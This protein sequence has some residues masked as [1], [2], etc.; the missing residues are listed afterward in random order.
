MKTTC[1]LLLNNHRHR[2]GL[3]EPLEARIAPAGAGGFDLTFGGGDGIA[4]VDHF[5]KQLIESGEAMTVQ[6]D[7][8]IL[9]AG[10]ATDGFGRFFPDLMLVR[11]NAN[12][13][14]DL[15][16]GT[17]G[18][19]TLDFGGSYYS[20]EEAFAI[21]VQ[22][23]GKIIV[24]GR[25]A[26]TNSE[27]APIDFDF[28]MARF[29]A[30]GSLDTG[31]GNGGFV[32]TSMGSQSDAVRGLTVGAGGLIYAVGDSGGDA[33]VARYTSAGAL[34][35]AFDTD[36]KVVR[37]LG[38]A[39]SLRG[40]VVQ[41][42]GKLVAAGTTALDFAAVRFTTSGALDAAFGTAGVALVDFGD[43]GEE[44]RALALD[45]SGKIVLGGGVK[46]GTANDFA[47]ARLTTAGVLDAT[48]GTGGKFTFNV[49]S[50]P[51]SG[52]IERIEGLAIQADGKIVVAGIAPGDFN[53]SQWHAARVSATGTLDPSYGSS[54]VARLG[55]DVATFGR[56]AGA[57]LSGGQLVIAG[58]QQ[59]DDA[60]QPY[61]LRAMKLTTNGTRDTA[62]D[63]DGVALFDARGST[64]NSPN[65]STVLADGSI[66]I[67][68]D[69]RVATRNTL[70]GAKIGLTHLLADGTRDPAFGK[71][72]TAVIDL[73]LAAS[74]ANAV[75]QQPDGKIL[76]AGARFYLPS[77]DGVLSGEAA[78][79]RLNADGSLDTTFA[80]AG[81]A[82][83]RL[84]TA[85]FG[86]DTKFADMV[87][88][89]DGKIVVLANGTN[90]FGEDQIAV[91]RYNANGTLD[92]SF[93][94]DGRAE[95]SVPSSQNS[96]M[97]LDLTSD[98]KLLL[99]GE[100]D[101]HKVQLLR[102]LPSG[103]LDSS[104][105]TVGVQVFDIEGK[106]AGL[107]VN[108]DGS[109]RVGASR[110]TGDLRQGGGAF[111]PLVL[112]VATDGSLAP[113]FGNGG[114]ITS[115]VY[116]ANEA[117][118][119]AQDADGRYLFSVVD[120]TTFGVATPMVIRLGADG[121][122]DETFGPDA[123]ANLSGLHPAY[124]LNLAPRPD[125]SLL[126]IGGTTSPS[127]TFVVRYTGD[128]VA[129]TQGLLGFTKRAS[130][131][132]ESEGVAQI[133]VAR[134]G[135]ST[136]TVTV[137]F[138][139][140]G[141]TA[142]AGSDFTTISGTLTFAPGVLTQQISLPI[143]VDTIGELGETVELTLA[144]ATGGAVLQNPSKQVVTILP[145]NGGLGTLDPNFGVN[146]VA[147]SDHS[148]SVGGF[149]SEQ[150]ADMAYAPNGDIIAV[151]SNAAGS[152]FDFFLSRFH[153][154]GS[155]DLAFGDRGSVTTDLSLGFDKAENVGVL[156]DGRILIAG[157]GTVPGYG[158]SVHF[159]GA[160]ESLGGAGD[161]QLV[162]ARYLGDGT[163]DRSYGDNG[164]V[165]F[166]P[167]SLPG[168]LGVAT[169]VVFEDYA[170]LPNG[171]V[172]AGIVVRD[173]LSARGETSPAQAALIHFRADGTLDTTFGGDGFAESNIAAEVHGGVSVAQQ[174]DGK[175]VL[176]YGTGD[177]QDALEEK[178]AVARFTANGARDTTFGTG[179][180]VQVNVLTGEE[181]TETPT[182]IAFQQD[183][184]ILLGGYYAT[185]GDDGRD[186]AD[187]AARDDSGFILR[188]NANGTLDTTF[189]T[190]GIVLYHGLSPRL[191]ANQS[192]TEASIYDLAQ[193]PNGKIAA[194]A[195][196][197]NGS[198]TPVVV[199]LL[200]DGTFDPQFGING[201]LQL[202]ALKPGSILSILDAALLITPSN[203]IL[204]GFGGKLA[205]DSSNNSQ[206]TLQRIT[207]QG[208]AGRFEWSL[209][210]S[211]TE[212]SD[213]VASLIV[214]RLGGTVGTATVAYSFASGTATA[215]ADFIALN[216][217]L[218]F[219]EGETSQEILVPITTGDAS[220]SVETFTATLANP[221]GGTTL[222][223]KTTQTVSILDG[224][225]RFEFSSPVLNFL[226][227]SQLV[228]VQ[229]LRKGGAA[230]QAA[231][232]YTLRGIEAVNGV[233]FDALE[234]GTLRFLS[235]QKV[236]TITFALR[237]DN[238][239]EGREGIALT[240]LN[241]LGGPVLGKVPT[242]TVSIYD[243]E[244]GKG[245]NAGALDSDFG[246]GGI[247]ADL[248]AGTSE[249]ARDVVTLPGG[250]LLVVGESGGHS[251]DFLLARYLAEGTLDTTFGVGGIVRT[252]FFGAADSGRSVALDA[253]GRI[254]VA[255]WA[256]HDGRADFAV[257]RYLANGT[258]DPSF[259]TDGRVTVDFNGLDDRASSLALT[260]DDRIVLAGWTSGVQ[261]FDMAVAVL[262]EDG[263]LDTAFSGD[264]RATVDIDGKQD[265][266]NA[267]LVQPDGA[268][269]LGGTSSLIF[270]TGS[271]KDV[272]LVRLNAA[273]AL[274]T[275]FAGDGKLLAND[276][277]T[278]GA[279]SQ[280]TLNTL[281]LRDDGRIIFGGSV[282][283]DI[284]LGEVNP[285]GRLIFYT[286]DNFTLA[287]LGG[288]A[289]LTSSVET[290]NDLAFAPDG[291]LVVLGHTIYP[292]ETQQRLFVKRYDSDFRLD[293][294]FGV[295]SVS[296]LPTLGGGRALA[297]AEDGNIV[298]VGGSFEVA[299]ILKNSAAPKEG[300]FA[301]NAPAYVIAENGGS[302]TVTVSRPHETSYGVV[303]VDYAVVGISAQPGQ[304]YTPVAGTLTFRETETVKT[305]T[306][307]ILNDVVAEGTEVF[308]ILLTNPTGGAQLSSASYATVAIPANDSTAVAVRSS[309]EISDSFDTFVSEGGAFIT[310][311][312]TGN[313]LGAVSI[314]YHTE[315]GTAK[316]G[317][318]YTPKFGTLN[319]AAGETTKQ[320]AIIIDIYA[321][322]LI[323]GPE[324]MF[325]KFTT[326]TGG[327]ALGLGFNTM[328]LTI[329]DS[330]PSETF[331]YAGNPDVTF[332]TD[333]RTTTD[334]GV[335]AGGDNFFDTAQQA[336]G[337]LVSVGQAGS[338]GGFFIV[339]HN[340]DGSLDTT[341]G[342]AG[343]TITSLGSEYEELALGLRI[344]PDGK[345][346]V[347]G[348]NVADG[349][350]EEIVMARYTAA[351][352]LDASFGIVRTEVQN[353]IALT[354]AQGNG[355]VEVGP[356]GKFV[357][358][359]FSRN[360][361]D[362]DLGLMRFLPTGKLDQTFGSGGTLTYDL[363]FSDDYPKG[364]TVQPD[365]K[366]IATFANGLYRAVRFNADGSVDSSF[367]DDGVVS[368]NPAATL[369]S[370]G[371][372]YTDTASIQEV[373]TLP[374][375][376]ILLLGQ[377]FGSAKPAGSPLNFTE[378]LRG[379]LL[380]LRYHVDGTP[381]V[382]F[383]TNGVKEITGAFI[384]EI[385]DATLDEAGKI[386]VVS[387]NGFA[388]M[389]PDG[390]ADSGFGPN[391]RGSNGTGSDLLVQANGRVLVA[392]GNAFGGDAQL[393]RFIGGPVPGAFRL[394]WLTAKVSES[395]GNLII[396]VER[397]AGLDG[398]VTVTFT[399]VSGTAVA[400]SDFT[401]TTQVLSWGDREEGVKTVSI[402][403]TNDLLADA[404]ETFT[405][406]LS[407]ATGGALLSLTRST[408]TATI[409]DDDQPGVL[410][411]SAPAFSALENAGTA[412]FTVRRTDGNLGPIS[413]SYSVTGGT[414]V[415][416]QDFVAFSGSV[417]F[418]NGETEKTITVSL[419][420]N[421]AIG[422]DKTIIVTLATPV[423]GATLGNVP[424]ARLTIVN[425]ET[426]RGGA[427]GFGA[428]QLETREDGGGYL[429][430]VLRTGGSN[431]SAS[432]S[433]SASA[434][435]ARAGL[436]F[437]PFST[438]LLFADG[439]T[440]A[441]A[442]VPVF[443]D[444]EVNGE[445][446]VLLSLDTP[447]G[448]LV[449]TTLTAP[450]IGT[451]GSATLSILDNDAFPVRLSPGSF[452]FLGTTASA[453]EKS[454]GIPLIVIRTDGAA[455]EASVLVS[456][457]AATATATRDF[458]STPIL[459]E[460]AD[461]EIS[462]TILVPLRNDYLGEADEK[463]TATL[464]SPTGGASLGSQTSATLTIIDDE[465]CPLA[466]FNNDGKLDLVVTKGAKFFL[467]LGDGNGSF[468]AGTLL[469]AVKGGKEFLTADFTGDGNADVAIMSAT[470]KSVFLL[471][472]KGDGTFE[473]PQAFLS[474]KATKTL[475]TGDFNGD[476]RLDLAALQSK[477]VNVLL[478]NGNGFGLP[479]TLSAGKALGALVA[480]DF[481]GDGRTDLAVTNGGLKPAITVIPS[482]GTDG[483]AA[484][485]I[486]RLGK[487][488][489]GLKSTSVIAGDFNGD[490][491]LDLTGIISK[492][493]FALFTGIGAGRLGT[494]DIV[495]APKGAK[496]I[497][498]AD[499]EDDL[500]LD[501]AATAAKKT[502]SAVTNSGSGRF[503]PGTL[504]PAG[505]APTKFYA[506][507]LNG[508]EDADLIFA[509]NKDQFKVLL[510]SAG[511][512]FVAPS[513]TAR[514]AAVVA[515]NSSV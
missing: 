27:E 72:G 356:D 512:T 25:S 214:Q 238:L 124:V 365:G 302:L 291:K 447:T 186:N 479:A 276:N 129:P 258:L 103:A 330:V 362:I 259:D 180:I 296:V 202:T 115:N 77:P 307:P 466:D 437:I 43:T 114:V 349:K 151:G 417:D 298:T 415:A 193:L 54:G 292:G 300:A 60:L 15:G 488:T 353:N 332:D 30:T 207:T 143:T 364:I 325:L 31:F 58:T 352:A 314:D 270:R 509:N 425:D 423:G 267:V 1:A 470:K 110:I 14:P 17:E 83:D 327:S 239:V 215:G 78:L 37:D 74:H 395:G 385:R 88:Q 262:L 156:P 271:V 397:I 87:L 7:G 57:A 184:K 2:A 52:G 11:L 203:D 194:V 138:S 394:N 396:P 424:A 255:G 100:D 248:F 125:G 354:F 263:K 204:A 280:T 68:E 487:S 427:F 197:Y 98:G 506:C 136:G 173:F 51:T 19:V 408:G 122:R 498:T 515:G 10:S 69:L 250:K 161:K 160:Q 12:G 80:N 290:I 221:T 455:G 123:G 295:S 373:V 108:G 359:A 336:D 158:A 223:T 48:F 128:P 309:F 235:G 310:V 422:E 387:G 389:L 409:I 224:P 274:D 236:A 313:S 398:A 196:S 386:I 467:H 494:Y 383:G 126:V 457:A 481:T 32:R 279:T 198:E 163:L 16:F 205:S 243:S 22:A 225:D 168:R 117:G 183:G 510:G 79:A 44:A 403:I 351:G 222:G 503:T 104:F 172:V 297:F 134:N 210:A 24:G 121:Q 217:T 322:D 139:I 95:L 28:A 155:P 370:P 507:D 508:D 418:A 94:G 118:E 269:V 140:T 166:D 480:G 162:L 113:S 444:I 249:Q 86:L 237:A 361:T 35:T 465:G 264:G 452:Q 321:D 367:G 169:D 472:G 458:D 73:G 312:R 376:D 135:G 185:G 384:G 268:I 339:R 101:D 485:L 89:P 8:K 319:F 324:T 144:T 348:A 167:H 273:G 226:E 399:A 240:L 208:A 119:F 93:A 277:F 62:F 220:E 416:G 511:A 381:D 181:S 50:M 254:V 141:G 212:E 91:S 174:S 195:T 473:T 371:L 120:Y 390:R 450:T 491:R 499:F 469:P 53:R 9:I 471:R 495:A 111:R 116:L 39:D 360:G 377:A 56:A 414:A 461:G 257:A 500:D 379:G 358:S 475:I 228:T 75:L 261:K 306:I 127:D 490:G 323:E 303:S 165:V 164:F 171:E 109:L 192:G 289:T 265:M 242:A 438:T 41:S 266:A 90:Y 443:D 402:P 137:N 430:T 182:S 287:Q 504:I 36:G 340:A 178:I 61:S 374:G 281:L 188:L 177:Y 189:S 350:R 211:E 170:F 366:I 299:Q 411:F 200:A 245:L 308:G 179:G 282:G 159:E 317:E 40:A 230:G 153:A 433:L 84:S 420:D 382:S 201:S 401:A 81:V 26:L 132:N 66:L 130:L 288:G 33:A 441:S 96:M 42:D 492:N 293:V 65:S 316:A 157:F 45:A 55:L 318:D 344:Q 333:G 446:T 338:S 148:A 449:L 71:N 21:A 343:K 342:S 421:S 432:V 435:T 59:S 391:G 315:D 368:A 275:T 514:I 82:T 429:V 154:D 294:N 436:D 497:V 209:A 345:L 406:T 4:I 464:S 251:S 175:F 363:G 147:L 326:P 97:D 434:G 482:K 46:A 231:V 190:D 445:R 410:A 92:T 252:D 70:A 285:A 369:L 468:G 502:V 150:I 29:T 380:M 102:L 241:P 64:D 176:A 18:Q 407:N 234:V 474:G 305:F 440:S 187:V 392:G 206:F 456:F 484:P 478:N 67:V 341:F 105:G 496:L 378:S 442:F 301:L 191:T 454:A 284:L 142:T 489:P 260:D 38:G 63:G 439:Q 477:G 6:A 448:E 328:T 476:G 256:L 76:L 85:Q 329:P 232:D 347:I 145:H 20:R 131:V 426:P 419:M 304:D 493:R 331:P 459:V 106:F 34:D 404:N 320:F 400:G 393:S 335:P 372:V 505:F 246:N 355:D 337:K 213:G 278:S 199:E 253:R 388:R 483:F 357:V 3:V 346:L 133:V 49:S 13:T 413:A 149:D 431:G 247:A 229:V 334:S 5:L 152:H 286:N 460:F 107:V 412:T 375:G 23:D 146:G 283:G 486:S 428:T 47:L 227:G 233:D 405:L 112:G 453:S 462:K 501:L 219:Q 244:P 451:D 311:K 513:V 216:G 272:A 218:T 99:G 463:F